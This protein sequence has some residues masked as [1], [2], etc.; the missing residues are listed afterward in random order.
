MR[1]M[2]TEEFIARAK[3]I[4][5]DKYD[6]SKVK[7]VNARTKVTIICREH[8][9]EFEQ[10]PDKHLHGQGCP[11][12]AGKEKIT[13]ELFIKRANEV[14]NGKYD[15]SKSVYKNNSTYVT[16]ICPEHGEFQQTPAAHWKGAGCPFCAG[17]LKMTKDEFI[18]RAKKV[19]D[20]AYDYSKVDYSGID[21]KVK[22]V[23]RKHN[24]EFEQTPNNHLHG[25]G[26]PIC[27]NQKIG[28][29]LRGN[30]EDFIAKAR[31]VHGDKYD[32]SKV[33]YKKAN[34]K[35]TIICRKHNY[36]FEQT[37]NSHLGGCGCPICSGV[38]RMPK[39]EFI[40]KAKEIHGD[41]YDYSKINYKNL[42]T[43]VVITCPDHGDFEQTP[44]KHLSGSGC[45]E[46]G[47]IKLWDTR[48][49]RTTE[50]FI[51]KAKEIHGDKYDYSKVNYIDC[52]TNVKIICK[53]HGEFEQ[54][55]ESHLKGCGCP[56]CN[57]GYTKQYKFNLLEEFENEYAFRA[58]LENNDINILLSILINIE[59]KYEPIKKDIERALAHASE[60]NPIQFLREK[61]S[62][63]TDESDETDDD[64]E[65]IYD[66]DTDNTV[67]DVVDWD[68]DDIVNEMISQ[69]SETDNE[70]Q[71]E[72]SIDDIIRNDEDEIR[73]IN[74]LD[75]EHLI[76]PEVREYIK[77]KYKNDMRRA[78]MAKRDNK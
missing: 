36:E 29:K 44:H 9:Y 19:H 23:C 76:T 63:E 26:C 53:E 70:E 14:H 22:I 78:W 15:Y 7:Y 57:K 71:D 58:F 75:S 54:T 56:I 33:K 38:Y 12:C 45:K 18:T 64:D 21:N 39:D 17:N 62:S 8:N 4:H 69:E 16:I 20:D 24:Y 77:A 41:K 48:G 61:Y 66:I 51:E 72:L 28:D 52:K 13:T 60:T 27:G 46:C 6:Y 74:R 55:P 34:E 68:D 35:V 49:R 67:D 11:I 10:V 30:T 50:W 47:H 37:P 32:Y 1:K 65:L 2:T 42:T 43:K 3:E 40:A 73:V 31:E 5:G 59:P 25:Q